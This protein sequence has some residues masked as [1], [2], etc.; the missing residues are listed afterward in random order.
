M[1]RGIYTITNTKTGK[2]YVGQSSNI[3]N[4]WGMHKT[5]LNNKSHSNYK[6][7]KDWCKYGPEVFKFKVVEDVFVEDINEKEE[8]W[9]DSFEGYVYNLVRGDHPTKKVPVVVD[10]IHD[11]DSYGAAASWYSISTWCVRTGVR[12]RQEVDCGHS[13]H[14]FQKQ[15]EQ[16]NTLWEYQGFEVY[17]FEDIGYKMKNEMQYDADDY[18][19]DP[20]YEDGYDENSEAMWNQHGFSVVD[21][22][23]P[24]Y[25]PEE[26]YIREE[27]L[28]KTWESAKECLTE[29]EYDLFCEYHEEGL[30]QEVIGKKIDITQRAVQHRLTKVHSKVRKHVVNKKWEL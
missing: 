27:L 9:I 25:D 8:F 13:K 29:E 21:A 14:M 30:T 23:E 18:G 12:K 17:S 19:F 22:A 7:L 26:D 2:T 24:S 20:D 1:T 15:E 6:L 10:G 11:F 28:E 16:P 3:E 5:Q 4:R